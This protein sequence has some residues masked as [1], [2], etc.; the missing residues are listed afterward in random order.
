MMSVLLHF[1]VKQYSMIRILAVINTNSFPLFFFPFALFSYA[2]LNFYFPNAAITCQI[3]SNNVFKCSHISNNVPILF[4]FLLEPCRSGPA[5]SWLSLAFS[6]VAFLIKR[7][8]HVLFTP[9]FR[10]STSF[11]GFLKKSIW[12][13]DV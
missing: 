2:Q 4:V 7:H 10:W 12:E 6:C 5:L 3:S 11:S 9:Y 13:A 1:P 8:L